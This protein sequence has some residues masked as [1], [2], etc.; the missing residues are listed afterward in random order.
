[1]PPLHLCQ[2]SSRWRIGILGCFASKVC[3]SYLRF[4]VVVLHA[5]TSQDPERHA[6][7]LRCKDVLARAAQGLRV[8]IL[9]DLNT[10][11]SSA[12]HTRV[13]EHVWPSKS[14]VPIPLLEI[15]SEH[16]LWIPATFAGCHWGSHET[17]FPCNGG[18]GSRLDYVIAPVGW[19]V[20]ADGSYVL[21][22]LDFG[23]TSIDHFGVCLHIHC[24]CS[25][26]E[27]RDR[28]LRD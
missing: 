3:H 21:E 6:W 7:W 11:F 8:L 26:A 22:G 27:G 4:M 19:S 10:R 9:G 14:P 17:W 24:A 20:P 25:A 16:D 12:I 23:Q 1:M 5:P 18:S 15:L 28:V 2:R 13:G